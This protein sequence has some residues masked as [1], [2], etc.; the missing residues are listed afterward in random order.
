LF[1]DCVCIHCFAVW[2][3]H[4]QMKPRFRH[5]LYNVLEKFIVIFVVW[6]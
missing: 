4:S 6:L 5:L 1:G 3:Q 2:F